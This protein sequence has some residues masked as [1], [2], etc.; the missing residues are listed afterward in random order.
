[1][2]VGVIPS[3]MFK[4]SRYCSL[5]LRLPVTTNLNSYTMSLVGDGHLVSRVET[6]YH[7]GVMGRY[8]VTTTF[9]ILRVLDLKSIPLSK[10]LN[11]LWVIYFYIFLH[12]LKLY[13]HGFTECG[14]TTSIPTLFL[15]FSP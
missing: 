7:N 6:I 8:Y 1:V 11:V 13:M 15:L 3:T 4:V 12:W 2:D 5:E 10:P 9:F 14:H